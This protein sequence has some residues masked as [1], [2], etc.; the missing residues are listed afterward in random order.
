MTELS[1]NGKIGFS[2]SGIIWVPRRRV[3]SQGWVPNNTITYPTILHS[4]SKDIYP[5][6]EYSRPRDVSSQFKIARTR[7]CVLGSPFLKPP[8]LPS[9]R[10]LHDCG[11]CVPRKT[12]GAVRPAKSR[13]TPLLSAMATIKPHQNVSTYKI[14]HCVH[15]YLFVVTLSNTQTD[16]IFLQTLRIFYFYFYYV[17]AFYIRHC[18]MLISW[19]IMLQLFPHIV[20]Y[21][22]TRV[23]NGYKELS[24]FFGL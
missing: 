24:F 8:L 20:T 13:T 19:Y 22:H 7:A 15:R 18:K 6:T 5:W 16:I 2:L 17:I 4:S 3:G 12:T 11:A 10:G 23:C 14:H 9:Q 21:R 1:M